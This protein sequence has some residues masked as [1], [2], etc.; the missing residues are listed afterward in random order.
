MTMPQA[1][2]D[3]GRGMG[4]GMDAHIDMATTLGAAAWSRRIARRFP[5]HA[6]IIDGQRTISYAEL[7]QRVERLAVALDARGIGPGDRVAALLVNGLPLVE[8]YLATARLGAI[9]LPLNW[10][11]AEAELA[12]IVGNAEPKIVFVSGSLLALIG[13]AAGKLSVIVAGDDPENDGA[14]GDNAYEA[15]IASVD[16]TAR[17]D[18]DPAPDL[19][20]IMLY[21]SG[22]TGR[23]KGCLLSQQGQ[24]VSAYAMASQW[25][26]DEHTRLLLSLP[27]FH[28][29]GTGLLFA[30]LASEPPSSSHHAPLT[31]RSP[32]GWPRPWNATRLPSCRNIIPR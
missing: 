19:P 29:G 12:W 13:T 27:L 3:A 10:R 26:S 11:L 15:L 22:T 9:L 4:S 32:G 23:P 20:W 1:G 28:V 30:H 5:G 14:D 2:A 16:E 7:D 21:T 8:L 25:Q 31:P 6:A 18:R 17:L 24:V